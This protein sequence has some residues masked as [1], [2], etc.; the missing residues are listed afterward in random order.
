M[1]SQPDGSTV[2]TSCPAHV[3]TAKTI[4]MLHN[5]D[6]CIMVIMV[7]S[8]PRAKISGSRILR[9]GRCLSSVGRADVLDWSERERD[10]DGD[11]RGAERYRCR[12]VVDDGDTTHRETRPKTRKAVVVADRRGG[13]L[14]RHHSALAL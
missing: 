13:F 4:T 7:I 2:I 6:L 1:K 3:S 8:R 11:D 12:T 14:S 5:W 9:R 10:G